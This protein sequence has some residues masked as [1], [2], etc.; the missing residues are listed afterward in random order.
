MIAGYSYIMPKTLEPDLVFA[1]DYY[2]G[3]LRSD[4]FSFRNTSVNP[5][6]DILKYRF[7]HT[8]KADIE[9][10]T[11]QLSIGYSIKYFS[12]IRN[13]DKAI[14]D[15]ERVTQTTGGYLQ[16]VLYMDY[17]AENNKG[18]TVM[19][20]RISYEF[21]KKYKISLIANNLLNRTYSLR[22]LKAEEV[23][24]IML[25]VVLNI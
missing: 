20:G 19:D 9:F 18:N 1:Q 23:R 5:E 2:M 21:L 8:L 3:T 25:Q 10:Y 4:S 22:P 15:F 24:T 11:G 13:L 17:Y 14:A 16:P 6:R 12:K 7:L